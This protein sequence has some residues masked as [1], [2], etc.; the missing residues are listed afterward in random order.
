[1]AMYG[2]F[3]SAMMGMMA[4]S[5]A[6]DNI[7]SNIANIGTSGFKKTDTRFA[8]VLS[9]SINAV[10]DLGGVKPLGMQRIDLGGSIVASSRNLDAAI[11]GKGFFVLNTERDGSGETFYTRDGSFETVTGADVSVTA[12][13]GVSTIVTQEAYLV[14]KNGYYVMAWQPQ[15][16]GSFNTATAMSAMRVDAYAFQNNAVGT[17]EA[18][19]DM[20]LPATDAGAEHSYSVQVFDSNGTARTIELNFVKQA[21]LNTWEVTPS[22]TDGPTTA[23]EDTVALAGSVEKDDVFSVTVNGTTVSYTATG[24]EASMSEVRDNLLALVKANTAIAADV[25]ATASGT[26]DITLT[27]NTAGTTFTSSASATQGLVNVARQDTVVLSGAI[28]VGDV[29]S[30]T[31]GTTT[32]STIAGGGDTLETLRNKLLNDINNN[33]PADPLVTATA[34]GT[35]GIDLIADTAGTDYTLS[36]ATTGAGAVAATSVA[37][38]YLA[39]A[40]N[41]PTASTT[42]VANVGSDVTGTPTTLTFNGDGALVSPASVALSAT[43]ADGGTNTTALDISTMSQYAGDFS[44]YA[45]WQN[46]YGTGQL[47]DISFDS[48]G[49]VQGQFTNTQTRALYR[50]G[51]AVFTNANGLEMVNGNLFKETGQSGTANI[52]AP[53]ENSYGSVS[54]NAREMSNVNIADEFSN[55]I[56]TQQAYNSASTIFRTVDEMTMTARDLKR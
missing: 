51:L 23:Q 24:A 40:D 21:A 9:N 3:T 52:I 55:M 10:S 25:T 4:Q 35:T 43:W 34:N 2:A 15:P 20:N 41:T 47:R 49:Q 19:L 33:V 28:T 30:I 8:T 27:A 14:D 26:A 22:W 29:Y 36:T 48:Q 44:P 46:G 38:N 12:D 5:T 39:L 37:N 53:G 7:G 16:D 42:T 17:T 11:S 56:T 32:F 6:L 50:M 13:D 1:M 54:G 45:Y 31:I 18:T